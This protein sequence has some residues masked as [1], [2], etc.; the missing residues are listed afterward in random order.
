MY[1]DGELC[2]GDGTVILPISAPDRPS[3]T[4]VAESYGRALAGGSARVQD[5]AYTAGALGTHHT[6]RR[7]GVV[8]AEDAR[9]WLE[10]VATLENPASV[11]GPV[12]FVYSGQ[13]NQ[14]P[15]MAETLMAEPVAGHVL[16]RC[17]EILG[18]C[19]ATEADL[20][21]P[22][23]LQ[24]VLVA[25]QVAITEQL[26]AWGIVADAHVGHSLGEISAAAACGAISLEDALRLAS[27]RGRLMR[28]VVD[29]GLTALVAV[30]ADTA[31]SLIAR[32]G[33]GAEIAAWNAPTSTLIAGDATTVSTVVEELAANDVFARVLPGTVAFHSKHIG[34]IQSRLAEQAKEV[35]PIDVDTTIVSTVTGDVLTGS[36]LDADYWALNVREPVR[37]RQAVDRLVELGYRAFVEIGAHPTLS[38]SINDC[39]A[40]LAEPTL[41]VP[42]LRRDTSGRSALLNTAARLYEAGSP[43]DFSA[44]APTD[45]RAIR[46]PSPHKHVDEVLFW[47]GQTVQETEP[48]RLSWRNTP[49]ASFALVAD[50]ALAALETP[51]DV[52]LAVGARLTTDG[53]EMCV[54]G[55]RAGDLVELELGTGDHWWAHATARVAVSG[56]PDRIDLPAARAR[57]DRARSAKDLYHTL[58]S[59]AVTPETELVQAVWSGA[60]EV[61]LE[62]SP[63]P[64]SSLID[65]LVH[66][67]ALT[68]ST[69]AGAALP[70][71]VVGLVAPGRPGAG[72]WVLLDRARSSVVVVDDDGWV[73]AGADRMTVQLVTDDELAV[74]AEAQE[75]V[76]LPPSSGLDLVELRAAGPVERVGLIRAYVC[77]ELAQVLRLPVDRIDAERSLNNLGV[78]SIMGLEL[79]RRLEAALDI[80]VKVVQLLRGDSVADLAA[81]LASRLD[82]ARAVVDP[83]GG[84]DDPHEIEQLMSEV[85]G[86][87]AEEV[88][89]LLERLS[90]GTAGN[91]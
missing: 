20:A 9:Q 71:E 24:P 63:R 82:E 5:L 75:S 7:A 47:R 29:T 50:T 35:Q 2:G 58:V 59:H 69:S 85:D 16:A 18:L 39:L 57:C 13:G 73:L 28:N 79:Q 64:D 61:L 46:L 8:T 38:P 65:T 78:D 66:A 48:G 36:A 11:A 44:M 53:R 62:L 74:V 81:D 25:L 12:A 55:N 32:H 80:E 41:V 90:T 91:R 1:V 31:G 49:L 88:D 72:R 83:T 56:V 4:E 87:S 37:F 21:D 45:R 27:I 30:P 67:S 43:V 10:G 3:L 15:G 6:H 19:V 22:A 76:A 84:L 17:S 70:V 54:A 52:R 23:V 42:T 51:V 26:A 77:G 33:G 40:G 86:M 60:D 14:W 34:P 89:A 68:Y